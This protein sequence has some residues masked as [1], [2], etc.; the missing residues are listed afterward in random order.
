M[1]WFR[2]SGVSPGTHTREKTLPMD[3]TTVLFT[4]DGLRLLTLGKKVT[5]IWDAPTLA[6]RDVPVVVDSATAYTFSRDGGTLVTDDG[7]GRMVLVDLWPRVA[8]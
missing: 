5:T 1:T 3:T 8:S 7:S 2:G 4:P 6:H